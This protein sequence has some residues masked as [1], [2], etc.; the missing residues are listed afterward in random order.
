MRAAR[1][2]ALFLLL[3]PSAAGAFATFSSWEDGDTTLYVGNLSSWWRSLVVEAANEWDRKTE[4]DFDIS[5]RGLPACDRFDSNIRLHPAEQ[6]LLNGVEFSDLLCGDAPMPDGV[7]A[8]VQSIDHEGFLDRVGMIFNDAYTWRRYSGPVW[9]TEIDFYRVALHELGHFMGLDHETAAAAIMQPIIGDI[10]SLQQDDIDGAN[11]LYG[12]QPEPE[13]EPEP[14]QLCRAAQLQAA[15]KLCKSTLACEARHAKDLHAAEREACAAAAAAS[16]AASWDAAL[17][18][19][20][21]AGGCAEGSDGAAMAPVVTAAA[22]AATLEIGSGDATDAADRALRGKLLKQAGTLCAAD[23][24]AWKKEAL[25]SDSAALVR[26]VDK[27]RGRFVATGT[28]AIGKAASR[29][30]VYEGANLEQ[31]AD[32]LELMANDL[33]ALTAP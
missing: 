20:A 27:A 17:A 7:L 8:V 33:A 9:E 30:V 24:A 19:A 21:E 14:L 11:S 32:S 6:Q 18:D 13:P 5:Y 2:A 10:D 23:L 4:F 3:A 12:E 25:R 1:L 31:V 22:N 28:A 29:G 26:R 15:T 16:F